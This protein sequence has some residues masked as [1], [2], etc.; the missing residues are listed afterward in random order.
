MKSNHI[1]GVKW[2]PLCLHVTNDSCSLKMHDEGKKKF[3]AVITH[4]I[5]ILE[6]CH[7]VILIVVDAFMRHCSFQIWS[8]IHPTSFDAGLSDSFEQFVVSLVPGDVASMEAASLLP[9]WC[10]HLDL[11][12]MTQLLTQAGLSLSNNHDT[13]W[14]EHSMHRV[15]PISSACSMSFWYG[16]LRFNEVW[17]MSL[18]TYRLH[19]TANVPVDLKQPWSNLEKYE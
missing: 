3:L 9:V 10:H 15:C 7:L 14:P 18:Y 19:M 11:G 12:G 16:L 2:S 8:H 4:F 5:P 6:Q 1:I 17:H 13:D